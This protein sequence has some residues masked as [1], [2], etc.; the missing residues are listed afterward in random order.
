[1]E[2]HK[3][4]KKKLIE[5][6]KN[7]SLQAISKK[8]TAMSADFDFIAKLVKKI[9]ERPQSSIFVNRQYNQKRLLEYKFEVNKKDNFYENSYCGADKIEQAFVKSTIEDKEIPIKIDKDFKQDSSNS[10]R[11]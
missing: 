3:F 10:R 11:N 1:M 9:N 2:K 5:L 6:Y 8:Q 7:L 4:Q